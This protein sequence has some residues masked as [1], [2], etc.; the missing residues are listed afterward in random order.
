MGIYGL[1][2][3][4]RV[5]VVNP[6]GQAALGPSAGLLLPPG[7]RWRCGRRARLSLCWGRP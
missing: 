2:L 7:N 6:L 5:V 4:L 3:G 1:T